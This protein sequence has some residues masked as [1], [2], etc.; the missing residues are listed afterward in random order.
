MEEVLKDQAGHIDESR[1]PTSETSGIPATATQFVRH[2]PL[3]YAV[4][5]AFSGG[6]I[7]GWLLARELKTRSYSCG[8]QRQRKA[9]EGKAYK[10]AISRWEGEGGSIL[11]T[12]KGSKQ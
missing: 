8:E 5:A 7:A 2:Y 12:K 9:S 10:R 6:M 3:L 11:S 1:Q 4:A